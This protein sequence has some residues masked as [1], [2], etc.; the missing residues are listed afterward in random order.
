MYGITCVVLALLSS[1]AASS[2]PPSP[3]QPDP[4]FIVSLQQFDGSWLLNDKLA[5]VVSRSVEE[6]KRCCPVSCDVTM[7]ANI[8]AT[9]V[10]I[11]LLKKKYPSLLDELELVIM[12]AEQWVG[13]QVLP[14]GVDL[15]V[16]KN[17]A[18]KI[19]MP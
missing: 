2:A 6:L 5:G 13:K 12:K 9:L 8:W 4:S 3:K 19:V 10:V 16:L 7:M 1:S 17:S 18:S 15:A 14:S 11:E